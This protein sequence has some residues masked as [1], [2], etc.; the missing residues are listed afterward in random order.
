MTTLEGPTV[1]LYLLTLREEG[2]GVR[3][4]LLTLKR[5]EGPT[6]RLYP[7]YIEERGGAVSPERGSYY[8]CLT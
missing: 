8:L 5:E 4:Y 6:V 2:P 3:L 1:H 7:V